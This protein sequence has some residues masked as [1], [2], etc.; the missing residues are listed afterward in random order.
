[1]DLPIFGG[2]LLVALLL[3]GR[4][5]RRLLLAAGFAAL[6]VTAALGAWLPRFEHA[7]LW[8]RATT[9][10][11]SQCVTSAVWIGRHVRQALPDCAGGQ[12][13]STPRR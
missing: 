9:R 6:A 11:L 1:M 10:A 3:L 4:P 5:G 2:L 7:S 13:R 8:M 12:R